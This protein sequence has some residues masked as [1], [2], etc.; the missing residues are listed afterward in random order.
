MGLLSRALA[1]IAPEIDHAGVRRYVFNQG[2]HE[3]KMRVDPNFGRLYGEGEDAASVA[4]ARKGPSGEALFDQQ[5]DVSK[6]DA[7][8]VLRRVA[9]ILGDDVEDFGAAQYRWSGASDGHDALYDAMIRRYGS[10]DGYFRSDSSSI[11]K[12]PLFGAAGLLAAGLLGRRN[13]NA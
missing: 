9:Q 10:P 12:W 7:L 2:G 4:F 8:A 6:K 13:D 3:F 11:S 5:H 1:K